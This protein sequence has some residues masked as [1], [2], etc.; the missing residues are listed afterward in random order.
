MNQV[1]INPK[2]TT[3][4][5]AAMTVVMGLLN[6][7]SFI[8]LICGTR[9][10]PIYMLNLDA[11][12]SVP[13]LFST[14]LLWLC[15]VFAAFIA[16]GDPGKRS[17]RLKWGGLALAF[18]FLGIDESLCLHERLNGIFLRDSG[19]LIIGWVLPYAILVIFFAIAYFKFIFEIPSKTRLLIFLGG[20]LF[21][22]GALVL[23][24]I[25]G[26]LKVDGM[27]ISYYIMAAMEE[28]LEMSGTIVFVYA[29]SSYIDECMPKFKLIVSSK[30]KMN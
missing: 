13:A 15:A 14:T 18:F 16:I 3:V 8:P 26:R 24:V 5:L 2:K 28:L 4:F 6:I 7:V 11:E 12:Q 29:F 23:E 22:T 19:F 9:D 27:G 20:A 10:V 17:Y 30:A 21:V 25:G 1:N